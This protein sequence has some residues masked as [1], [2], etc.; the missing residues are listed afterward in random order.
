MKLKHYSALAGTLLVFIKE[1]DGQIV[2]TDISDTTLHAGNFYPGNNYFLDLNNDGVTDF[3]FYLRE[4]LSIQGDNS[5]FFTAAF[6]ENS[7][8]NPNQ[9][10]GFAVSNLFFPELLAAG[11]TVGASKPWIAEGYLFLGYHHT[12]ISTTGS[13]SYAG[14]NIASVGQ[15]LNA[16]NGFLGLRL[17]QNTDTLY[18]WARMDVFLLDSFVNN[19]F[20][21]DSVV[22]KDYAYNTVPGQKIIAGDTASVVGGVQEIVSSN[23]FISPNPAN[24]YITVQC[25]GGDLKVALITIR[26][27]AG[28]E[29]VTHT[30]IN[31][32]AVEIN[33]ASL[34]EGVY[35]IEVKND[36]E[37]LVKK[38]LVQR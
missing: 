5:Q 15:W 16:T 24:D 2:Y 23:I 19:Q 30:L 35:F 8:G 12:L 1:G 17:I 6:T 4:E 38:F 14:I 29:V 7:P 26:D 31:S 3:N 13:G 21:R 34:P 28:K 22:I 18:G 25:A 37:N 33:V 32:S 20:T 11:D 36:T 9:L 27:F 10:E